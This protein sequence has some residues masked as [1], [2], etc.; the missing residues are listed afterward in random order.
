LPT[1]NAGAP[2]SAFTL[3]LAACWRCSPQGARSTSRLSLANQLALYVDSVA[4]GTAAARRPALSWNP[5]ALANCRGILVAVGLADVGHT[6][7]T[8]VQLRGLGS[9]AGLQGS[10]AT[11]AQR[12]VAA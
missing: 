7:A 10:T 12:E 8:D 3:R 6:L 5:R 1:L 11:T 9:L 4:L 2:A